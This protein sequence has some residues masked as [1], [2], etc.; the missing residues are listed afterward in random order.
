MINTFPSWVHDFLTFWWLLVPAKRSWLL[1]P[2][3]IL[4]NDYNGTFEKCPCYVNVVL[5][6]IGCGFDKDGSLLRVVCSG[7][8]GCWPWWDT[9]WS[10]NVTVVKIV[11]ISSSVDYSANIL[12]GSY[13]MNTP[14]VD[15]LAPEWF[16]SDWKMI[17]NEKVSAVAGLFRLY[18]YWVQLLFC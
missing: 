14:L 6:F 16:K 15:Q 13:I 11:R 17:W 2:C 10:V 18:P 9:M 7:V 1:W 3:K 5:C 8:G 4:V 12:S